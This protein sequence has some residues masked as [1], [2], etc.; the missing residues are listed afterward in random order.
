MNG[1][2]HTFFFFGVNKIDTNHTLSNLFLFLFFSWE[3][4]TLSNLDTLNK[5]KFLWHLGW[6]SCQNPSRLVESCA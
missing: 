6:G 2:I 3:T 1:N 4:H 5:K